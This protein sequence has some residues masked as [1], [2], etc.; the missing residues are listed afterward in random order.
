[1]GA[2]KYTR[3]SQIVDLAKYQKTRNIGSRRP[4]SPSLRER[5]QAGVRINRQA[6]RYLDCPGGV[7]RS[8][9]HL[10]PT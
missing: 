6:H 1:M 9:V 4:I 7:L 8:A 10:A 3:T 2:W 5:L